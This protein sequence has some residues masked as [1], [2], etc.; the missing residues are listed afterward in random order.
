MNNSDAEKQGSKNTRFTNS[1]MTRPTIELDDFFAYL[2]PKVVEKI[3][4]TS[5]EDRQRILHDVQQYEY[6]I[7]GAKKIIESLD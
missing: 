4:Q 3:K 7:A 1:S 5:E 2:D 6:D